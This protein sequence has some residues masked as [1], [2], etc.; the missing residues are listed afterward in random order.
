MKELSSFYAGTV[1]S[2]DVQPH[3]RLPRT[4]IPFKRVINLADTDHNVHFAYS[5]FSQPKIEALQLPS[6]ALAQL[7]G[8][9]LKHL[10]HYEPFVDKWPASE[11]YYTSHDFAQ[12][13]ATGRVIPVDAGQDIVNKLFTEAEPV[14]PQTELDPGQ[15][16]IMYDAYNRRPLLSFA[17]LGGNI[18]LQMMGANGHMA[19]TD[20]HDLDRYFG[21]V[22]DLSV[23]LAVVN[24]AS[25]D[26][27]AP[28]G[29]M[30]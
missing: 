4:Q 26:R 30:V 28:S 20:R 11:A 7:F 22:R 16:G 12:T 6:P 21:D 25:L 18:C 24:Q 23:G 29:M 8:F 27:I 15:Y 17:S 19:I 13:L 14:P 1:P 9:A 2:V 10:T 5:G 3:G